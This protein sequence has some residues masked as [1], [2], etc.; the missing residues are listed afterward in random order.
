[1]PFLP[2]WEVPEER[3]K[4]YKKLQEA[5]CE[6][7]EPIAACKMM[8]NGVEGFGVLTNQAFYWAPH[9]SGWTKFAAYTSSGSSGAAARRAMRSNEEKANELKSIAEVEI[10][11]NGM[12]NIK[13]KKIDKKTGEFVT[14]KKGEFKTI[15][16][17]YV[18]LRPKKI[19]KKTWK[20]QRDQFG[21][22]VKKAIADSN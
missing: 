2:E 20:N 4:D 5:F 15:K 18:L 11:G 6:G 21:E 13:W 7:E 17:K 19:D 9:H 1:M 3:A 12:M 8:S 10:K 14:N 16:T 22:L